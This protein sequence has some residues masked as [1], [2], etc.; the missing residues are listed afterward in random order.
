MGP[1]AMATVCATIDDGFAGR[2]I[3]VNL[4]TTATTGTRTI[5]T[6]IVITVDKKRRLFN[7]NYK[8]RVSLEEGG[9]FPP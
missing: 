5:G 1:L 2:S 3:T 6:I 4:V 9:I 7:S 8:S